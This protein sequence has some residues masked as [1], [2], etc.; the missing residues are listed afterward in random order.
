MPPSRTK[1][2]AP[3]RGIRL[4][5]RGRILLFA[6]FLA[7]LPLL[8]S[9]LSMI[10]TTRDELKSSVNDRLLATVNG[11]LD[12]IQ[13]TIDP[14]VQS[15]SLLRETLETPDLNGAA[16]T[17][18]LAIAV[19]HHQNLDAVALVVG[20]RE[21]AF[22]FEQ[23][24]K[25]RLDETQLAPEEALN[26]PGI[27]I[28]NDVDAECPSILEPFELASTGT[29]LLPVAA[30]LHQPI[31]G[32]DA[33]LLVF[34]DLTRIQTLLEERAF[35]ANGGIWL[36]SARRE[37]LFSPIGQPVVPE[38]S[39]LLDNAQ[40]SGLGT[41]LVTPYRDNQGADMLGAVGIMQRP[42]WTLVATLPS[43]DAYAVVTRMLGQLGVW[44]TL[45]LAM[46]VLGALLLAH[47]IS[48]PI[49]EMAKVT[50]RVGLGDLR[51]RLLETGRRDEIGTLGHRLNQM[52]E[53]LEESHRRLDQQAH[54][55][56]LTSLPNR[57]CVLRH[58]RRL[59][60]DPET[61][62]A[63]VALLFIDLDRF[64]T[65][66]DSLG[67]AVGDQLLALAAKRLVACVDARAMTARLGGDEFLVVLRGVK[68]EDAV[69]AV[70]TTLIRAMSEPFY[71]SGHELHIGGTIGISMV[72]EDGAEV[73]DLL[74]M[75]DM[76]MYSAKEQG[77]GQYRF[78]SDD[79][80]RRA[81]R[82]L[83][84]DGQLRKALDRD[85]LEVYYQPQ[86]DLVSGR[87]VASE[88]LL[89]WPDQSG[90]FVANPAELIPLAE[91]TG[92]IIPIGDWV[93]DRVCSQVS[94]WRMAGLPS[95]EV[96]INVSA[97]QFRRQDFLARMCQS[98]DR[99]GLD[100][101]RVGVELTE[102]VLLEDTERAIAIMS[103]LKEMG[104]PVMIDDFG[105]GYS[106]LAY[107]R[108]FPLDYLK[109]AQEFVMG[110]GTN[111]QDALIV[112]AII[113]LSK[114]LGLKI[115]AEGVETSG[116][117]DFLW[118]RDCDLIQGFLLGRPLSAGRFED[119]LGSET[120]L[121]VI[122]RSQRLDGDAV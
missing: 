98:L 16:K 12:Q 97:T 78:F 121:Q 74:D 21:P 29:W 8:V 62:R 13:G 66:N 80:K 55:D 113:A 46:A 110:I 43:R 75:S 11:L 105:T 35:E 9:S 42:A 54:E 67:H 14:A 22:L 114:S 122:A 81:V 23:G 101:D 10:A 28:S 89:R 82:K 79:L 52:I 56:H 100:P 99:Y 106:S 19:K 15:L 48:Q 90:G 91:E 27:L 61:R 102:S 51:A 36:L 45:G 53:G 41:L 112:G 86:V 77:R 72:P 69:S 109:V 119:L 94:A 5:L 73:A 3:A 40:V 60:A 32:E 50:D 92:L 104:M 18:I 26:I 117:L 6:V 39:A 1:S 103:M 116:Q 111:P 25:D 33:L 47:R 118:G 31:A 4:G 70:A 87:I 49:R 20:Q 2:F 37:P 88:A 64:K 44:L 58:L 96:S 71:L 76:A 65:V 63:G 57:R 7:A 38:L 120:G 68:D 85:E 108:L 59:V 95:L 24:F 30:R 107:L 115:I 93:M 34:L 17:A 84:L 83:S